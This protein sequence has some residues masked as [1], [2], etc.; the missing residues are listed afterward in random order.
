M[1]F[2]SAATNYIS[3]N[4]LFGLSANVGTLQRQMGIHK[5][6]E[7]VMLETVF[8]Q[9]LTSKSLKFAM[10]FYK[11]RLCPFRINI[12]IEYPSV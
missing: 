5:K 10:N 11:K 4:H 3:M 1:T 8:C 9:K 12:T 2:L 6:E 7:M